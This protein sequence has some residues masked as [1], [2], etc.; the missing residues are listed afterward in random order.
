MKRNTRLGSLVLALLLTVML[1]ASCAT[2]STVPGT[3]ASSTA[4]ASA[5]ATTPTETVA[6]EPVTLKVG[7]SRLAA[8]QWEG[9]ETVDNNVWVNLYKEYGINLEVLYDVN[10]ESANDKLSQC[11]M[12]GEY[13]DIFSVSPT[14]YLDWA[15][16]GIFADITDLYENKASDT[17]K[18]YYTSDAG[19]NSLRAAYVDGKLY[20][21]PPIADPYDNMTVLWV[22]TDWLDKLKLQP[23]KTIDEF[24]AIAKA[25]TEDDPDG[26]NAKD[27][28]G[29]GLNGSSVFHN[30][31]GIDRTLEM[32]GAYPGRLT[33]TL[34]FVD[35][36]G[37]AVYGGSLKENMTKGLSTLK[38]MYDKGYIP[39]DFITAGVDQVRQDASVGKIGMYFGSMSGANNVWFN[40]LATQPNAAFGAYPIPGETADTNGKAFYS[41]TPYGFVVL[42]SKCQHPDAWLKIIEL[43]IQYLAHPDDLDEETFAKYNGRPGQYTGWQ[44]AVVV[45]N[46]PLKNYKALER[47][48]AALA[49]DTSKLNSENVRDYQTIQK[50]MELK[51][52]PYDKLT[53]EEL[54]QYKQGLFYYSVWG[55]PNCSYAAIDQMIKAN[56]FVRSAYD[57]VQT[58]NMIQN[59][60]A[61]LTLTQE[62]IINII[63]GSKPIDSYNDFLQQFDA[64]GGAEIQKEA[65]EWYQGVK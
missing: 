17:V 26:N 27:T 10:Q 44:S 25:F 64:L 13:P 1:T 34:P 12:S 63:T 38:D 24:V 58:E 15:H 37:K 6:P 2:A 5:P 11:I 41:A 60:P 50:Y 52:K 48:Q 22:R 3:T 19:Q 57:T 7:Y 51:D 30:V 46:V 32:F 54:S 29:L 36:G 4:P 33:N 18:E 59:N 55:A 21:L 39:K 49:G 53:D 47:Q 42:S 23:P 40:A 8:F 28:Y 20:S 9:G 16:Q 56:R 62:M 14:Q 45:Y 35:V 61:L 31:A 65:D 43:S